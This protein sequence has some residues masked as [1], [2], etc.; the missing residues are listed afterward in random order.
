MLVWVVALTGAVSLLG[1]VAAAWHGAIGGGLA[2]IGFGVVILLGALF[3]GRYGRAQDKPS[4][5]GW[6]A[7]GE[8]FVDPGSGEIVTVYYQRATG[9]RRYVRVPR[10]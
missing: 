6:E 5:A 2:L 7:T 4:D 9:K 3:E 8:R 1:G 10:P